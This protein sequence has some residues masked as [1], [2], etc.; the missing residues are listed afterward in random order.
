MVSAANMNGIMAPMKMPATI[1]GSVSVNAKSG[2][3]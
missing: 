3:E 1:S 2:M